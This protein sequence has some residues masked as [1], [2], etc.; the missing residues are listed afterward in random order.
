MQGSA[1]IDP[2]WRIA[3]PLRARRWHRR[4]LAVGWGSR[5][6]RR[7][8][9]ATLPGARRRQGPRRPAARQAVRLRKREK[10]TKSSAAQ[11]ERASARL[12]SWIGIACKNCAGRNWRACPRSAVETPRS[13]AHLAAG[14]HLEKSS[15]S[16]KSDCPH[17]V[18]A[19]WRSGCARVSPRRPA[20][21]GRVVQQAAARVQLRHLTGLGLAPR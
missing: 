6:A 10:R 3:P 11:S 15:G 9:L 21:C 7:R 19:R 14:R 5:A 17:P 16:V 2:G 8:R 18:E 20:W 1:L 4:C 13:Q 12:A